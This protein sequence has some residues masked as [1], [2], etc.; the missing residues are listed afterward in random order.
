MGLDVGGKRTGVAVSDELGIIATP[1]Q[2]V[3]RGVRDR[4]EFRRLAERFSITKIVAGLPSTLSGLEGF[5]AQAARAYADS[6]AEDLGLPLDYWDER[7]TSTIAERRMVEAGLNRNQRK[8]RIDAIAAAVMLQG[9]LD[10]D[11]EFRRRS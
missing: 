2:F 11:A 6:L 10:A 4:D 9:Y 5:Q 3:L 7:L 1:I 8:E